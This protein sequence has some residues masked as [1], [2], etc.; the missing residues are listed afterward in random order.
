MSGGA[1]IPSHAMSKS[2]EKNAPLPEILA[3]A[4][5]DVANSTYG[6]V[7]CTAVYNAYYVHVITG[8]GSGLPEGVG[9]LLLT[10]IICLSSLAV[11]A[12]APIVGTIC[13]ATARKKRVLFISTMVCVAGTALLGQTGTG[14]VVEATL[15]LTVCNMFFGTGEDLV[16]A[17][18]PELATKKDMGRVSSL[19][20][21]AGYVGGLFSL[22]ISF[23]YVHWAIHRGHA[24]TDYVPVVMRFCA[25]FFAVASAPTFLILKER[26]LPD[27]KLKQHNFVALGFSR[28]K[29]TLTHV[30]HYKDLFNFLIT[31]FLYSCGT[32]T[33]IHLAS[34]YAQEVI[35]FT[36][37]D[38]ITMILVVN[39]TAAIGAVIFG[40]V[41]DK[42]GA[43]KTL[44]I[45]LTIWTLA[46]GGA[47]AAQNKMH[48]WIAANLV[49]I[50]MGATGSVG[51]A[52][53]AQFA[54]PERSG[55][56]LGLWGVAV[57]LATAF[58]AISFGAVSMLTHNNYRFAILSTAVYFILGML[59][60]SRVNEQRGIAAA[61]QSFPEL[62]AGD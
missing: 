43:I 32:T 8:A 5:Y 1:Q 36:P 28:L 16:A 31:L 55:E 12:T 41:Q 29:T 40:F 46:I 50:A 61:R 49:G 35:K 34:V 53:V 11:V 62:V 10:A 22:G 2:V 47:A 51:R 59:T 3:W 25:I 56:F 48:L 7:V 58:G 4:A 21:A 15:L 39:I 30:Q 6:T 57:K 42:V 18:L 13:D 45:T 33:V 26:A 24:S 44:A 17:F 54:P 27:P 60:L 23:A 20:W 19:G 14:S 9:T 52:L 37:Q 38:S